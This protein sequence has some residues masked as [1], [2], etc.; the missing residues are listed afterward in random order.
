MNHLLLG[1]KALS[2]KNKKSV[3]PVVSIKV[4]SANNQSQRPPLRRQMSMDP[5]MFRKKSASS[6]ASTIFWKDVKTK[7]SNQQKVP[8]F[9]FNTNISNEAKQFAKINA[10]RRSLDCQK[11]ND[12]APN[13][14]SDAISED[15]DASSTSTELCDDPDN[16]TFSDLSV[17]EDSKGRTDSRSGDSN[18]KD[19]L[20]L[21]SRV[22]ESQNKSA[23]STPC[24]R[25]N[26][27]FDD[28]N[29]N[30][31]NCDQT[32]INDKD[33]CDKINNK[34]NAKEIENSFDDTGI[35][36]LREAVKNL[37]LTPRK[38]PKVRDKAEISAKNE[39]QKKYDDVL[40]VEIENGTNNNKSADPNDH[41]TINSSPRLSSI[42][43]DSWSLSPPATS[44]PFRRN[45]AFSTESSP[46]SAGSSKRVPVRSR[47][48]SNPTSPI[49]SVKYTVMTTSLSQACVSLNEGRKRTSSEILNC[50]DLS[51]NGSNSSSPCC[52][53]SKQT[54]NP[55]PTSRIRTKDI[56]EVGAKFG[57]YSK[58][59]QSSFKFK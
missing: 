45:R 2:S 12:K 16:D 24:E 7:D 42:S 40:Q 58:V 22:G 51:K 17:D 6:A 20:T 29:P 50:N 3:N 36:E 34:N 59:D 56:N 54:F 9:D 46:S 31:Y 14:K 28:N 1:K 43:S 48:M 27:L 23:P 10:R 53:P 8:P 52:S 15:D 41:P 57:M 38:S 49:K 35:Q 30:S 19:E 37:K 26:S 32:D 13:G 11:S 18:T 39:N 55:F 44:P 21:P 25:K 47:A 33:A 5:K 4:T